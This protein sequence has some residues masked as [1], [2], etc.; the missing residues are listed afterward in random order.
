MIAVALF[1]DG[2]QFVVNWLSV[3]IVTFVGA[4]LAWLGSLLVDIWAFL[5]FYVW[6][7]L[8]GISFANPKRG[9]TMAGAILIE[10]I[11]VLSAL[12]AWTLAVVIC[13]I[14]TRGEEVLGKALTKVGAAAGVVGTV[15]GVASKVPMVPPGLKQ[16][17]SA[18]SKAAKGISEGAKEAREQLGK[19]SGSD[20]A[21]FDKATK[22]K[23]TGAVASTTGLPEKQARGRAAASGQEGSAGRDTGVKPPPSAAPEAS[24]PPDIGGQPIFRQTPQAPQE[25]QPPLPEEQASS[26]AGAEHAPQPPPAAAQAGQ[27]GGVAQTESTP[28]GAP[29]P[30]TEASPAPNAQATQPSSASAAPNTSATGN[31]Q[32]P[33]G[34]TVEQKKGPQQTPQEGRPSQKQGGVPPPLPKGAGAA[35]QAPAMGA[36]DASEIGFEQPVTEPERGEQAPAQRPPKIAPMGSGPRPETPPR[37]SSVGR[38]APTP[39]AGKSPKGGYSRFKKPA[40]FGGLAAQAEEYMQDRA[41]F[42]REQA[43]EKL[44]EQGRRVAGQIRRG[45]KLSDRHDDSVSLSA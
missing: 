31:A 9:L 8:H 29:Q 5:T 41:E 18:T 36:K 16:G 28:Q 17:L 33:T 45:E 26:A 25:T 21:G 2:A 10:I 1:Y 43:A 14:T 22:Q 37:S 40:N 12:P 11:P 27:D 20:Q 4:T 7:K 32:Q 42:V 30:D 6:F 24:P 15:A 39:S 3:D 44:R 35:P 19:M 13:F 34:N 23:D 38:A